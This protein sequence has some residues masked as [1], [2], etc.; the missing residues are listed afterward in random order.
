MNREKSES[1]NHNI[2]V[3]R[4]GIK[5]IVTTLFSVILAS[6][7][8]L[9]QSEEQYKI[10]WHN[11]SFFTNRTLPTV[12]TALRAPLLPDTAKG[13]YFV[14]FTGPITDEMKAQVQQAGGELLN[15]VPNNTY[16]V[17]MIRSARDAVENLSIIQFV[18][19]YQSN[20]KLPG[21]LV[22]MV[23][24]IV[25]EPPP[26]P[27]KPSSQIRID[28]FIKDG[29]TTLVPID[30]IQPLAP[31]PLSLTISVFKGENLEA[32]RN[33]V[34]RAG[35][36]IFTTAEKE[37]GARLLISL[38]SENVSD[39][40]KING[41]K[42]I[43]ERKIFKLRN[44]ESRGIIGV[45]PVWNA[46][47]IKLKGKGQIIGITD[48]GI[49]LG[50]DD[51]TMHDDFEGRIIDI[52]SWEVQPDPFF[53]NDGDNDLATDLESG[54]GT[55]VAGSAVGNGTMSAG[56][57]SGMAPEADF[58]FQAVEQYT[59]F[60]D[61]TERYHP[62][63]IPLDLN[64]L[65]Q[66]TYD[67]GVRIHTNSWGYDDDG[68]YDP[69]SEDVDEFVW[70][71]PDYLIL[72]AAGNQGED[73][74]NN[75]VIDP[76]SV[77]SP[78][79]AKN[80]LSVGG[81]ENNRPSIPMTY[82]RNLLGSRYGPVRNLDFMAD[83]SDGMA[84]FSSRGPTDN[85]LIKPDVVAP[86]TFVASTR[87]QATPNTLYRSDDM[88]SGTGLWTPDAPWGRVT[89]DAVYGIHS[90][91]DSPAGNYASGVDINLEWSSIDLSAGDKYKLM[92]FWL[93]SDLGTG[94]SLFLELEFPTL[95][96]AYVL[97]NLTGIFGAVISDWAYITIPL[98][99]YYD[100]PIDPAHFAS[101]IF[102]FR[103][104][105]NGDASTGD[106]V[107]ID[108]VYIYDK[109]ATGHG[110]LSEYGLATA[111]SAIDQH[112]MF[113]GGTSMSTPL[114]AGGAALV[115]QYYM[116]VVGLTYM[117]AALIRA[118]IIN[119]AQDL[120][121]GQYAAAGVIEV[122]GQP[123]NNQGWGR[124]DIA[125]S[126][127]PP[128]PAVI[129]HFD[130]LAGLNTF[131]S[132][133]YN[134]KII[135][136]GAPIS[137]T[138][139]YH[140]FPGAGLVNNLDLSVTSPSGTTTYFPNGLAAADNLNNVERIIIPSPVVGTYEIT[141]NGTNVPQGPQPYAIVV[142]AGGTI[143]ERPPVDIMLVLDISG[144]MLSNACPTCDT[145]LQVLKDAVE[146]FTA[147]WNAM[148]ISDDRIG[149]VYFRTNIDALSVG[150]S[151]L[152][153]VVG[154]S[155]TI[156]S[157]V[158][159]QTTPTP[160]GGNLTA[161]GGG[162]QYALNTLI[163]ATRPRN[164]IL[165]TDGMQNVNPMVQKIDDSPPP[166]AYHLEIANEPGRTNSNVLPESPPEI[167]NID[168]G[169]KINS[170]AVIA[171]T[172]PYLERLQEISSNTNGLSYNT[173]A[174]D[175]A[176]REFYIENL[177]NV[178]KTYS[179]QIL[180]YRYS[181]LTGDSNV[182][183]FT[184]NNNASKILFKVS[185]DQGDSLDIKVQKNSMDLTRYGN[186]TYG[187]FYQ[188]FSMDL[189]F[190]LHGTTI[191]SGG[192]WEVIVNGIEG[193]EYE[194]AAIVDEPSF[195]YHI[196]LDK[197]TYRVNDP[198]ELSVR[199]S[200]GGHPVTDASKVAVTILTPPQGIGT[201]LSTNRMPT[202]LGSMTFE[203]EATQSQKKLQALIQNPAMWNSIQPVDK[204]IIL[205][206]NGDGSYST[207]FTGATVPGSY[208]F[209]INIEGNHSDIGEYKRTETFSKIVTF[210]TAK[211]SKS[212]VFAK[213]LGVTADGRKL[214]LHL[215]P[216]DGFGNYLGPDYGNRIGVSISDQPV[217]GKPV[218]GIDGSYIIPFKVPEGNDPIVTID[219]LD[220]TLYNGELS[221]LIKQRTRYSFSLH[222]G[223]T[224]PTGSY[225]NIFDPGL[226]ILLDLDYHFTSIFSLVAFFGYNDF[227]SKIAGVDDNYWLNLSLNA[228]YTRP[229]GGPWS[230][231]VGAGPGLYIPETGDNEPGANVGFGLD[232]DY[233]SRVQFELGV[234]YHTIFDPDIQF[235][236]SHAGVIFRF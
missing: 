119:G 187:S 48:T 1:L 153:P 43:N 88:E 225:A 4:S 71:H 129:D 192:E 34:L 152:Y 93:K 64:D 195:K 214:E 86:G 228:R 18:G 117:S 79:T 40:A 197:E 111:G 208:T 207:S 133:S 73:A 164:I 156:I 126:I 191:E 2:P 169:V 137:V 99:I 101:V 63:G 166:D 56:V 10:Q 47:N 180:D 23:E 113:M 154:N 46:H 62:S 186:I 98:E 5:I 145:K 89:S 72:F 95:G 171:A 155:A 158:Q 128:S 194:I 32:I 9:A 53:T 97:L 134:L 150:G 125:N 78:A 55:H 27:T 69:I 60:T 6:Q 148:T 109:N 231:Y 136:A 149:V 61:G 216:R 218:D 203:A 181:V 161:M 42:R 234:D 185:W 224:V 7:L 165:F 175:D 37:N 236:H 33:Q 173:T 102:K 170:I 31:K 41:I 233:S 201:F 151:D 200:V 8:L 123:D 220:H 24:G 105:A 19:R 44:D 104:I 206:N 65:F 172:D 140:D 226:N 211:F 14:Q 51:A 221:G 174:P 157:D 227:K 13:Y 50:V 36:T 130:Q 121:P 49:D 83:N 112:Y 142:S 229:W 135:D 223:T 106:G 188:I 205:N 85:N 38:P 77:G 147:V 193:T 168:L 198:I 74:N 230:L 96:G 120:S 190:D 217:P 184:A 80:C 76:G 118:T 210:N 91:H 139:V 21:K 59:H 116:D 114:V 16:I 81:S 127:F 177:V 103:L 215:R 108:D 138:M 45:S 3:T 90:W 232:Y 235:V 57:Y 26:R 132:N 87:T 54:H 84:A 30:T 196:S 159:S 28:K 163:E 209:E 39:L 204:S 199:L 144:S 162:L 29:D 213:E 212:N 141:V 143:E 189:P 82:Q 124:V 202:G 92:N 183:R 110:L 68:N 131:G 66:Q 22:N 94:D 122:T 160:T 182:E 146:I 222:A 115:R 20:M 219:V 176:L 17:R 11:H 75:N 100:I 67:D 15:Y 70:N 107:Y 179:P 58:V 12:S 52:Y 167:I 178:L 35:G 25:I